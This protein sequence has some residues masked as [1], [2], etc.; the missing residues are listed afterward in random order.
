MKFLLFCHLC[1][2]GGIWAT[3]RSS[4]IRESVR[5]SPKPNIT[6]GVILPRSLL[7]TVTRS[8]GKRLG[9]SFQAF[10]DSKQLKYT[11]KD[12]YRIS[13]PPV[14]NM[15]LNPSPTEILNTL[16]NI[17]VKRDVVAILY[18]TN[19]EI[20]G[21]NAAS[22][23]YLLQL[24]TYMGIPVIAWNADNIGVEQRVSGSRILQ[25]APSMEHQAAAML[26][27]LKRYLWHQFSI[28]TT[29][30]GGHDD[31]V[32]AVRDIV[33]ESTEFKFNI[34][35]IFVLKGKTRDEI[36]TELESLKN[37][38]A[39]VILLYVTKD[40]GSNIMGAANDLGITGKNYMWI[41]T[42]SAVGS[43]IVNYA[44][45]DFPIGML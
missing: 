38:D 8:Y 16:C 33:L 1:F 43:G 27:I 5:N 22:V 23:Q 42:Q 7:I 20:Y 30:I 28:V 9:E 39:R 21:S 14:A 11:F 15:S 29:L 17:V 32:R 13:T 3:L 35:D 12:Y 25:L 6:F 44:P 31:F 40:E 19:S 26:S 36:R 34:L 4:I 37:S 18:F 10:T 41:A 45:S 2:L 24:T